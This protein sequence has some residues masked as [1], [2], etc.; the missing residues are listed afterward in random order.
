M[1]PCLLI[2]IYDHGQT[3][4]RVVSSLA[5]FGLPLLIIDDGSHPSTKHELQR[6]G[7]REPWITL[8]RRE[9]NGG[10]GAA[11]K[12][13]YR[14]ASENGFTHAIQLDADGQHAATDVPRMINALQ[15]HPEA[16]VLGAPIFD[17]SIPKARLY[18]RQLSRVT[19]WAATLSFAVEDPLCGFRGVPLQPTLE[20]LDCTRTGD[21]MEFDPEFCVRLVWSGTQV[22]NVPTRVVYDPMGLSHFDALRDNLRLTWTYTRLLSGAVFRSPALLSNRQ[23]KKTHD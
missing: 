9:R 22:V 10:R 14:L 8:F 5:G 3:I 2:P 12:D 15:D 11:L 20:L 21:H 13:G 18:G 16:L 17:A 6:I 1:N 4:D 19:V 7:A 23:K